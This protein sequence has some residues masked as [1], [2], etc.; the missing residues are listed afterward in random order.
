LEL[1]NYIKV[2]PAKIMKRLRNSLA[3]VMH[4]LK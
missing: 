3:S 4:I 2:V 1:T